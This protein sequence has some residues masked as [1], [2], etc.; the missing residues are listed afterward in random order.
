V[1]GSRS[2]AFV[3]D[4]AIADSRSFANQLERLGHKRAGAA[5]SVYERLVGIQQQVLSTKQGDELKPLAQALRRLADACVEELAPL[6]DQLRDAARV[7]LGG[8]NGAES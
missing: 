3:L 7:A 8:G 2:L 4:L 1:S 6:A 5:S